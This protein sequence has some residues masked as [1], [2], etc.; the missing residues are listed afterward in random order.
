M[1]NE[2][3]S[4]DFRGITT[5]REPMSNSGE[6][7]L[8]SWDDLIDEWD[9]KTAAPELRNFTIPSRALTLRGQHPRLLCLER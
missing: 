4:S 9:E 2:I 7:S 6:G 8:W 5:E 1:T 3:T